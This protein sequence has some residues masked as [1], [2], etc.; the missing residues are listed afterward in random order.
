MLW[1]ESWAPWGGG[2]RAPV[3]ALVDE[4]LAKRLRVYKRQ[5]AKRYRVVEPEAIERLLAP[6]DYFISTKL[7]GELWFLVKREGEVA[8]CAFN[9]RVL[10]GTPLVAEAERLLAD[11]PDMIFAGELT[12]TPPEHVGRARVHHVATAFGDEAESTLTFHAFDVVEDDG[13]DAL[14]SEYPARF[15]RMK[16]LLGGGDRVR[17][18]ETQTGDPK[19]VLR[20]YREWV[21]SDRFEGVVV[22]SDRGLTYKIKSTLTLDAVII[23]YGERITG[24]VRQVREMSVALLRDDGTWQLLG[25]VGGGFSEQDRAD[26]HGRLSALEVPSRFRL[27]NREGTLSK[28]VRPEIVVEIRCSDLLATDSWDTQIRR[29]SLRFREGDGWEPLRETPMAVMIHPVFLRERSDKVVD[30]GAVGMTQIT[31][32]LPLETPEGAATDVIERELSEVVRRAVFTK[33][34]K[35]KV[36]VRKYLIVDTH[37]GEERN[38][39]PFLVYFTDYSPGRKDALQTTLRTAS[40]MAGAEA[41]VTAWLDD[42][43]KRGWGEVE[44]GRVGEPVEPPEAARA[45]LDKAKA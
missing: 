41:H 26:W 36:A 13:K 45:I 44:S 15:E 11:A 34:T 27:A 24:D 37:K 2:K 39:A 32:R 7:D 6:G 30:V 29:M 19:E 5:V 20:L 23:A 42:N 18:A 28:F 43:I 17:L 38:Y 25:A 14:L 10:R 9:G 31:S 40:T 8:L 22:R 16:E 12:A 33:T 1:S 35:D 3:G 4:E 21:L